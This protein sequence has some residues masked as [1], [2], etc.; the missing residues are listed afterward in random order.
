LPEIEVDTLIL[1]GRDDKGAS[2]ESAAAA[3]ERLPRARLVGIE[4]C[5]HLP[6]LEQS[7]V[8]NEAMIAFLQ[9]AR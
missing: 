1:W 7:G 9:Y 5:G 4:A 2:Y 8:V 6:M 3:V